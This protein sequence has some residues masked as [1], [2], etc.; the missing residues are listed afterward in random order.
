MHMVKLRYHLVFKFLRPIFRLY[1]RLAFNYHAVPAR[2]VSQDQP[3]LVLSNH[4]GILDPFWLALSFR[5]PVF[6]VASDHIFRL[7]FVSRIIRWLVAPIPIV[8]SQMDLKTIRTIRNVLKDNGIVGLFPEGN[9]SFTGLSSWISP[10]TGKLVKQMGCTVLL[11]RFRGGYLTTPRWALYKRKGIMSG[12][13]VRQL[14]PDELARMAPQEIQQI[15][16]DEL[17]MDAFAEQRKGEPIPFKGKR[18]AENL[19]LT[20][21]VCPKCRQL[22][23]LHSEDD[24][25]FCACSLAVRMNV[26]GFFEPLDSWSLEQARQGSFFETVASWDNWQ[27]QTLVQMLDEPAVFDWSGQ[28]P[29]FEDAG[30]SLLNCERASRS[31]LMDEGTLALHTDRLQFTGRSGKLYQYPV[32]QI[33]RVITHDPQ[34]LQFTTTLGQVYEVRSK[35]RRSAYKYIILYNLLKQRIEGVPIVFFGI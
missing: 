8:K 27:R 11:Y 25:F 23:T 22:V 7:G 5:R 16:L 20:L 15:I 6:F 12:E 18:L 24:R 35:A 29:I 34:T 3:I 17:N 4:T 26:F 33:S 9:T 13:V 14:N 30:Q 1:G 21:F 28:R 19:E 2:R 31:I 10:S 32:D